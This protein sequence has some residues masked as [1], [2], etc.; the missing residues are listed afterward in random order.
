MSGLYLL[1]EGVLAWSY[2]AWVI[3]GRVALRV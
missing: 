2:S 1:S 3:K